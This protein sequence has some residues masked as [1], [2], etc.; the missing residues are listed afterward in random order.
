MEK[1][2]K[3]INPSR[4]EMADPRR[5]QPVNSARSLKAVNRPHRQPTA[6]EVSALTFQKLQD[7]RIH[8]QELSNQFA[9]LLNRGSSL[10]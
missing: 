8:V 1:E 5:S 10:E 2:V 9:H 3:T 6:A 7:V 4:V